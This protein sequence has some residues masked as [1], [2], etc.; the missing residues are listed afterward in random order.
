MKRASEIRT[1]FNPAFV[2]TATVSI[3]ETYK[4]SVCNLFTAEGNNLY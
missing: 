1:D 2:L 4:A 3:A